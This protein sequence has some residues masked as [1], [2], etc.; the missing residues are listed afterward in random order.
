MG[1]SRVA[2]IHDNIAATDLVLSAEH[3]A[4]LEAA[5]APESAMIFGLF[6]PA[7]RQNV[8]FGGSAVASR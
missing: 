8:V 4:A 2:Q 3:L 7:G 6:T 5:T 1:V